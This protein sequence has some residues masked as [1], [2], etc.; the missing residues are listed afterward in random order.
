[1][2]FSSSVLDFNLG[3]K[4][5]GIAVHANKSL[6]Y[7]Q[8]DSAKVLKRESNLYKRMFKEALHIKD[9]NSPMNKDFKSTPFGAHFKSP[10]LSVTSP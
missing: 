5:A 7:I 9:E 2:I 1:M 6:H 4:A 8:W 3:Q 10:D